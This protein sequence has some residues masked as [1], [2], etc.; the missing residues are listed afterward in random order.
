[1]AKVKEK[2]YYMHPQWKE[3]DHKIIKDKKPELEKIP[4][5]EYPFDSKTK[6]YI[7]N[8]DRQS[9]PVFSYGSLLNQQ[10]ARR[11]LSNKTLETM[12]PAVAFGA[13]RVFNRDI[14]ISDSDRYNQ[15]HPK[16]RGMLNLIKT[17]SFDD[18]VNGV[19]IDIHRS[20]LKDI[21]KREVGYDL[22][23]IL[24]MDW[25]HLT[26]TKLE[27]YEEH[28]IQISFTF[29]APKE[30]RGGD[31][32]VHHDILPI[33]QY[34]KLVKEG[35]DQHGEDYLDLFFKS[36]YLADTKTEIKKWEEKYLNQ[37]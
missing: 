10:S 6:E 35:A 26:D 21:C 29:S 27:N 11:H 28:H 2:I 23:P 34:Y 36:T 4:C 25:K 18:L 20:D 15:S 14:D 30:P 17:D 8:I 9:I 1:M 32:H 3:K 31:K 37:N 7:D 22:V 33:R 24:Y 12:K 13:K 16:E 19:V 5:F